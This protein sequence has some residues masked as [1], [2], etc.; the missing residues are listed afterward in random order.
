MW[1]NLNKSNSFQIDI[2]SNCL[3]HKTTLLCSEE[4]LMLQFLTVLSCQPCSS[5]CA[6]SNCSHQGK[7]KI[8]LEQV[9][10]IN[11]LGVESYSCTCGESLRYS[12]RLKDTNKVE[13]LEWKPSVNSL[14]D[15][16]TCEGH[17][18]FY[19][20]AWWGSYFKW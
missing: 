5:Q 19:L 15:L 14:Q 8:W 9:Q 16:Q 1:K 7:T 6:G 17:S 3:E 12:S 4:N 18:C 2:S 11:V 20:L 10:A 13:Q